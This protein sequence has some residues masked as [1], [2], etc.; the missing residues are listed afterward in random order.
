MENLIKQRKKTMHNLKLYA[1]R[2]NLLPEFYSHFKNK[3]SCVE[4][5]DIDVALKGL[6]SMSGYLTEEEFYEY[7][8]PILGGAT[9]EFLEEARKDNLANEGDFEGYSQEYH[10][11][12][13]K[14]GMILL[15]EVVFLPLTMKRVDPFD[16]LKISSIL[17]LEHSR[18]IEHTTFYPNGCLFIVNSEV[19][20]AIESIALAKIESL[21]DSSCDREAL[22][23][24][25][26]K[27]KLLIIKA[28]IG[29]LSRL[30]RLYDNNLIVASFDTP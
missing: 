26:R 9:K 14:S 17:F 6:S 5:S 23:Q 10:Q 2:D 28:I 22:L 16:S 4:M 27:E 25:D 13:I 8:S 15:P 29:D 18:L 30:K 20:K 12:M 11:M 21:F 24:A 1:L 7:Y 19:I 3:T